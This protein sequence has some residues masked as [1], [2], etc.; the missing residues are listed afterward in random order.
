M[1]PSR[2]FFDDF[3]DDFEP[4]KKMEKMMKCDIYEE[5]NNYIIEMDTP[6]R[7]KED[8]NI[9]FE[10]GNLTISAEKKFDKETNK[11]EIVEKYLRL[12]E[13]E[14][15]GNAYPSQLSGGMAQRVAIARALAVQPDILLLDEP[16]GAL[17]AITRINMQQEL[18]RIWKSENITMI[19]ITHDIDEAVF[20]GQRVAVMT[21]RPGRIKDIFE[22]DDECH[23]KRTGSVFSRTKEKIYKEFFKDEEVPFS[24]SI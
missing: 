3:L 7:R 20:L 11:K 22:I 14:K 2:L 5:G 17:D 8:I 18:R 24:Y 4:P 6:G 19:L 12:V 16:F 23:Y 10:D 21:R 15:F 9:E 13:L 1:L